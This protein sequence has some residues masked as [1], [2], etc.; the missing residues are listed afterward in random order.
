MFC[1]GSSC[2]IFA[3]LLFCQTGCLFPYAGAVDQY[4]FCYLLHWARKKAGQVGILTHTEAKWIIFILLEASALHRVSEQ[5]L[6]ASLFLSVRAHLSVYYDKCS[7]VVI[8]TDLPK[9]LLPHVC[10]WLELCP[11]W[12]HVD[13]LIMEVL[14]IL[15]QASSYEPLRK[16]GNPKTCCPSCWRPCLFITTLHSIILSLRMETR[17]LSVIKPEDSFSGN[18]ITALW[19]DVL[20]VCVHVT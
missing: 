9:Q 17:W 2:F 10:V 14:F 7:A 8:I 19:R 4:A 5:Q 12:S 16:R 3:D 1:S 13:N 11:L 6:S 15:G 20:T 18:Q